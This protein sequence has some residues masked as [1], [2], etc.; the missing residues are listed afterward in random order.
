MRTPYRE[1]EGRHDMITKLSPS[2]LA[3][4]RATASHPEYA[5][6]LGTLTVGEG[7]RVDVAAANVGRQTI[8]NRINAA[9][10]ATGV[11]VKHLRSNADTVVF[12]MVAAGDP[13]KQRRGRPPKVAT[14]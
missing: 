8:K 14:Q 4:L 1:H 9:A 11:K 12:E 2:D 13:P 6:F 7:G 3:R 5:E 10:A